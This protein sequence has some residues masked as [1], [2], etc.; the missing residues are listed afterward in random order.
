MVRSSHGGVLVRAECLGICH[1]APAL[2]LLTDAEPAGRR[3]LL[4]GPVEEP[5]HVDAVIDLIRK[6]DRPTP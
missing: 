3:G 5:Q 4:I 6:A 2:L 1:R